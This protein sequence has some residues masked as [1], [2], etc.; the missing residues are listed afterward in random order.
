MYVRWGMCVL[1][2]INQRLVSS[3]MLILYVSFLTREIV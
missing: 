1:F 3:N 2:D